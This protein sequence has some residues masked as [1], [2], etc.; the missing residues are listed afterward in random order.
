MKIK[1]NICQTGG[2]TDSNGRIINEDGLI[3]FEIY[4]ESQKS[5]YIVLMDGA[6]G[7]GKNN[8]FVKNLTSAEWYVQFML[9]E[10]KT[11]HK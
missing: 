9:K 5:K 11:F 6:S 3:H 4:T 10:F 8:E 1:E 2:K 7:L